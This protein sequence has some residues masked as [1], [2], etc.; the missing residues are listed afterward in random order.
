MKATRTNITPDLVPAIERLRALVAEVAK[1]G[2]IA[3]PEPHPDA[4]LLALCTQVL[5]LTAEHASILREARTTPDPFVS[6]PAYLAEARCWEMAIERRRKP[7]TLIG[8]IPAT[9]GAGLYAKAM[10]FRSVHSGG[11]IVASIIDDLIACP[12]LR[13]SLWPAQKAPTP[14]K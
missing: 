12:G 13:A 11:G 3:E 14:G 1:A 8:K 5:D 6:N 9:T 2:S 4:E 10:A 7:L